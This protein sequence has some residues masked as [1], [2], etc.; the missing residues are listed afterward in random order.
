MLSSAIGIFG[1]LKRESNT[2]VETSLSYGIPF[3][4]RSLREKTDI[5]YQRKVVVY[6]A[7]TCQKTVEIV[8]CD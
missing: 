6:H 8:Y 4:E 2:H 7:V 1:E 3:L 5:L